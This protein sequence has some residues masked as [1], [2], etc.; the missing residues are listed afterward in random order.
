MQKIHA[1]EELYEISTIL[2]TVPRKPLAQL[3]QQSEMSV[4]LMWDTTKVLF[5]ACVTTVFHTHFDTSWTKINFVNWH[6][7]GAL[8]WRNDPCFFWLAVMLD[9]ACVDTWNV[10]IRGSDPHKIP[11][12]SALCHYMA[13]FMRY[14]CS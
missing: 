11:H 5:H 14:E 10:R 7:Q 8:C 4:P 6:L 2:W 13:L 3:A 9:V 1:E 12:N